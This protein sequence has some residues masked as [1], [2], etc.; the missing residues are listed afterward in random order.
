MHV[1]SPRIWAA[2]AEPF[3]WSLKQKIIADPGSSEV[4]EALKN[5]AYARS[6]IY[7]SNVSLSRPGYVP[8]FAENSV[9]FPAVNL[10]FPLESYDLIYCRGAYIYGFPKGA[11]AF[12]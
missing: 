8:P 2:A 11:F 3:D 6:L 9:T 4:I 10:S 1:A 7:I 12:S 5:R